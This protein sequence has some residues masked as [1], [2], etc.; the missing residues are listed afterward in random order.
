ML[1]SGVVKVVE[2]GTVTVP[3]KVGLASGAF[4][5]RSDTRLVTPLSGKLVPL[6]RFTEVGVPRIG[7]MKVALVELLNN[8]T[9]VP[10]SSESAVLKLAESVMVVPPPPPL[11]LVVICPHRTVGY[12]SA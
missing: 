12:R 10:F 3:V 8:A 11:G 4:S 6:V 1:I 2:A 5:A 7:V 9:P